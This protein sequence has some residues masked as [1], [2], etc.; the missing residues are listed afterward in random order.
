MKKLV[1]VLLFTFIIILINNFFP[2]QS[3]SKDPK[4]ILTDKKTINSATKGVNNVKKG[5]TEVFGGKLLAFW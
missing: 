1:Q 5:K 4:S 3:Y 2:S